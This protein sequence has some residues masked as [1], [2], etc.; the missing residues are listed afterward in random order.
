MTPSK[1][2]YVGQT[3]SLAIGATSNSESGLL[4]EE[5]FDFDVGVSCLEVDVSVATPWLGH[6]TQADAA[7]ITL[8]ESA[9]ISVIKPKI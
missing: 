4:V 9:V 5:T 2:D 1:G 6:L 7:S 3:F 8:G